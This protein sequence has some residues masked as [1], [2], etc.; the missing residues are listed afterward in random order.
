MGRRVGKGS[1]G[2]WRRG[3]LAFD[4]LIVETEAIDKIIKLCFNFQV[5][6][7]SSVAPPHSRPFQCTYRRLPTRIAP[8][9]CSDW[10]AAT[11]CSSL[12]SMAKCDKAEGWDSPSIPDEL[13]LILQFCK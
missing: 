11:T 4:E 10:A 7:R 1:E 3:G 8:E 9:A 5:S 2:G 13:G 6:Q 12:S